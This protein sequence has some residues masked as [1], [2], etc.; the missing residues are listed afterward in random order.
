MDSIKVDSDKSLVH[1]KD[2]DVNI[3]Y[4]NYGYIE[5]LVASPENHH[6][7]EMG[8]GC[9]LTIDQISSNSSKITFTEP[10][11][12]NVKAGDFLEN[13]TWTPNLEIKD[14]RILKNH[15]ARGILVTTPK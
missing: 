6:F 14:S 2:L 13:K 8:I 10:L 11:P 1:I 7:P 9:N 12:K 15:R 3:Y 5:S 4:E